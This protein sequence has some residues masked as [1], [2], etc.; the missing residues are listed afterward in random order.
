MK[1]LT[2]FSALS[3]RWWRLRHQRRIIL[4]H[5]SRSFVLTVP[6][7]AGGNVFSGKLHPR[8][9]LHGTRA[10][11]F[12]VGETGA[13]L[14]FTIIRGRI[15]KFQGIGVPD[16]YHRQGWATDMVEALLAHYPDI[17]FYNSSLNE[18]SGPLFMKLHA[19]M[20]GRIAPIRVHE[21]GGY[22]V[23]TSWRPGQP[24]R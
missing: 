21:E 16:E 7:E 6:R 22:E 10:G 13:Y 5:G 20:P 2:P 11:L 3:H 15:G 9:Q 12:G 1:V 4:H 8:P 18:M 17:Y 14:D 23:D 19:E 24:G